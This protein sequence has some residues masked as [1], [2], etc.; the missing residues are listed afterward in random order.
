MS[1]FQQSAGPPPVVAVHAPDAG[2]AA[3]AAALLTPQWVLT[4]AHVVNEAL[5]LPQLSTEW[6]AE[7]GLAVTFARGTS[8]IAARIEK[9]VPPTNT[10]AVWHGDLCLL[11]LD[12]P[13]PEWV[14]PVLW[15]DMTQGQPLRA[16]HSCGD[17]VTFAD[18]EMK[19]LDRHVGYVDGQLS[20]A[21]IGPGFSGGPL[22]TASGTAV[23][24][25][26]GRLEPPGG[27]L[28]SG[29][30]LR[31]AWALPWQTL[32]AELDRVGARAVVTACR[33]VRAVP[34]HDPV[35]AKLVA[36]LRE[37]LPTAAARTEPAR[38]LVQ[39]LKLN[40]PQDGSAPTVEELAAEL[41]S[42]PR[43]LPTI[44]ECLVTGPDGARPERLNAL[45]ALGR[46]IDAAGLLSHG[47]YAFLEERLR[48][49]ASQDSML[50]ARA[51]QEALRFTQP[52]DALCEPVLR[53]EAVGEVITGLEGCHE[54]GP[55]P[56]DTPRVP[57][58]VHV[59]EF[60][61]AGLPEPR[62]QAL[63]DWSDRV[64]DR[65]GV[66]TAARNQRRE[67]ARQWAGLRTAPRARLLARLDVYGPTAPGCFRCR[68]WQQRPD[69]SQHRMDTTA[70]DAPLTPEQVATVI[71]D[72]AQRLQHATRGEPPAVD[73]EVDRAG[74]HLPLDEWEPEPPNAFE[75]S[76][77]LGVL[78]Q[79]TLR[80]ADMS[81]QVPTRDPERQRRWGDGHGRP[82]VIGRQHA[83][84]REVAGLLRSTYLDAN[85]VVLH[86]PPELRNQLLDLCLALGVPVVVWD[87]EAQSHDHAEHLAP[88]NPAGPLHGLPRRLHEFRAE[89]P[90]KKRADPSARQASPSL[91]WEDPTWDRLAHED[92][93]LQLTDPD[94]GAPS[95]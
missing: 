43:A 24:L 67:D 12:E 89:K 15:A 95:R 69:G 65:L 82:L 41:L 19:L 7:K 45:L 52:P 56:E 93:G 75:P 92:P 11:Q 32:R 39:E 76:L 16:W 38:H 66:H 5:G 51:A 29:H 21:P 44:S 71:R 78:Y 73:I 35:G 23:G 86:G 48:E 84:S 28:T 77:P 58:L 3:G 8:R 54:G 2:T 61:A 18:V 85:Q 9:W 74:L 87:R 10:A 31:R 64:C 26:V 46:V 90:A 79:L 57:S 80:S 17:P 94:E 60:I 55:G 40:G 50:P 68:L 42:T 6:P 1:W 70:G 30:T 36:A 88:V 83:D 81:R 14:P 22:W 37:L 91:V 63:Q 34:A 25:V 47:E 20:G 53:P 62:R 59:V 49:V 33:T 13:A 72:G 27:A 4:C